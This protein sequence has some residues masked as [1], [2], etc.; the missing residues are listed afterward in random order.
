MAKIPESFICCCRNYSRI[1]V[2]VRGTF[3]V[4]VRLAKNLWDTLECIRCHSNHFGKLFVVR[5]SKSFPYSFPLFPEP[6]KLHIHLQFTFRIW[7]DLYTYITFSFLCGSGDMVLFHVKLSVLIEI[8][9]P[10]IVLVRSF[11]FYVVRIHSGT[12]NSAF[13]H[14]KVRNS[15]RKICGTVP[16]PVYATKDLCVSTVQWSQFG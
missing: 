13:E 11:T 14:S 4:R 12:Y 3:I 1:F 8:H 7:F 10:T 15:F 2:D 5:D 9:N 16:V 6:D